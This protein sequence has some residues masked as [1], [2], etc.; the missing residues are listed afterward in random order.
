LTFEQVVV[1]HQPVVYRF[2]FRLCAGN[3]HDAEDLCQESFLRAFRAFGGLPADAN[4]RA[5][6]CR[7]AYNLFLNTRRR[8]P[9]VALTDDH[10]APSDDAD[11]RELI[12]EIALFVRELPAK[13]RAA[14]VLRHVEG[15]EYDEISTVLAC[16]EEAARASVSEAVRKVRKRFKEDYRS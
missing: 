15:R 10:P 11:G 12:G 14:L 6:V 3:S 4:H 7:I 9:S 8:R 13:Q 1:E 16:S 5:W 2:L